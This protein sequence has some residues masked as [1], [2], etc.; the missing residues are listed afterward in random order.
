MAQW[1]P[2]RKKKNT[3]PAPSESAAL[4]VD[5][6]EEIAPSF[7]QEEE[8]VSERVEAVP[9]SA[10]EE[11]LS[12][13]LR[14]SLWRRGL[15]RLRRVFLGPIDRLFR[16]RPFSEE[17]LAELE[18]ALI[19][20]DVGV[21]TATALV[22]QLRERCRKERPENAEVLKTY[23]KEGMLA[24]LEKAPSVPLVPQGGK[25]WV[26]LM[27]GVNGVGKTTTIAK[28]TARFL[29][30]Q[31]QVLLVAGDTFRAAAIEQLEVWAKRLGVDCVK[32]ASG[33]SP[34]AVAFDGIRAAIARG[35]DIVIV[36]TAGRL[37]TK[38]PLME[39]LKKV[40]RVINKELPGAPHEVLLVVDASTGQ[41][42]L[43]QARAFQQAFPLTG[44]VLSKMDGSA[45]GGVTFA[46]VD[47]LGVPIRCVG[48][49]EKAEDLQDFSA[50]DFVEAIF[51]ADEDEVSLD[52]EV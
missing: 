4:A 39:E 36:D 46:I 18:E 32:H 47:Q 20:A 45:R 48:L 12:Q 9:V 35:V 21:Q 26:L 25:P 42:A 27:V 33:A 38:T 22:E 40:H 7:D 14:P 10:P 11:L 19:T 49:G 41:N 17:L 23:L 37:H 51:V 43:N 29:R 31:Q 52:R 2:W 44:I 8:R 30:K 3:E 6:E 16:G 34:A 28:L 5:V 13:T 1:L 24:V 50:K 15:S